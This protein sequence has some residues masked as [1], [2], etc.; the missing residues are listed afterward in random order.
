MHGDIFFHN[1]QSD[2]ASC[3]C[4]SVS[5]CPDLII[6][7]EY[8]GKFICCYFLPGVL[9]DDADVLYPSSV[10]HFEKHIDSSFRRCKFE[11]IIE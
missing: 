4:L 8:M 1:M 5:V 11:R 2:A 6:A 7:V 10:L 3:C 9:H